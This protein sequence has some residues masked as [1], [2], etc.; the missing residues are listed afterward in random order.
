M[1]ERRPT[2]P[3]ADPGIASAEDGLVFLDGPGGIAIALTPEAAANTGRSLIEAS[4]EARKQSDA[5]G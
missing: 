4:Q 2:E 5:A 1:D 3:Y